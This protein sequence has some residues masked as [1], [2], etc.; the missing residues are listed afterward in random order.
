MVSYLSY[1]K[2]LEKNGL[3]LLCDYCGFQTFSLGH[4]AI[5]S[6]CE[7]PISHGEAALKASNPSA[8]S[9][10]E[11][12]YKLVSAKR[13]DDARKECDAAY[14]AVADLGY[15]YYKGLISIKASNSAVESIRYDRQGFMEENSAFRNAAAKEAASA[16]GYFNFIIST[17]KIAGRGDSVPQYLVF[18]SNIKLHNI[19]EASEA[20]KAINPNNMQLQSYANMVMQL[21]AGSPESTISA[22]KK[23]LSENLFSINAMYYIA[24]ALADRGNYKESREIALALLDKLPKPQINRLIWRINSALSI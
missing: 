18:L 19:K 3:M 15:I 22:A 20:L 13:F 12:I 9:H 6:N 5:C 23:L 11:N 17:A 7:L 21:N 16:R 2:P 8:F 24:E 14:H 10:A 4:S 1:L